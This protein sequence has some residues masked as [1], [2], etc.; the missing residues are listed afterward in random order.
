MPKLCYQC[1][2]IGHLQVECTGPS[3]VDTS[4]V[5][6]KCGSWIQANICSSLIVWASDTKIEITDPHSMGMSLE[7]DQMNIEH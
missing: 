6:V 1:G 7:G 4:I 5:S 3:T 2:K